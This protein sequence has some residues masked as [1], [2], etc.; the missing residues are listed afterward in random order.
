MDLLK[1]IINFIA[2][3]L[4]K[5]QPLV[6]EPENVDVVEMGY[7]DED[8]EIR[9]VKSPN[10]GVKK[11]RKISAIILHHTASW[12]FENTIEW[13]VDP[14]AKASAHYMISREGEIVQLVLDCNVAWHA[15]VSELDGEKHVNNFSVGIELI[16]NTCEKPL[17]EAQW[18]AMVW[19]VKRLMEKYGVDASRVVD[20]RRVSPG[21]KVDLD[22]ENF[23]WLKF[24]E[25]I[26]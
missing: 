5:K 1:T 23:D 18:D 17:T 24:Y 3:L 26:N 16:G 13:L 21:R 4:G 20:H 2:D 7:K 12:N 22:P 14:S 10:Y 8:R 15:G 9:W 19:L 25:A 6:T 11:N